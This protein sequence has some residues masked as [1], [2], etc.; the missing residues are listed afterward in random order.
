MLRYFENATVCRILIES[1]FTKEDIPLFETLF[2]K[3]NYS[4]WLVECGDIYTLDVAVVH[5]LYREIYTKHKPIEIRVHRGRLKRYLSRLGFSLQSAHRQ[6]MHVIDAHNIELVLIGGSADS[7]A[8][9]VE[10]VKRCSFENLSLIIVQ[11]QKPDVEANFDKVLQQYTHYKVVYAKEFQAIQKKHIYIAPPNKHLLVDEGRFVFSDA[12]KY[13]FSRPSISLSYESFSDYY[14][15]KLLV[16]Q[17]CGYLNDGVD[18][19]KKLKKNGSKI[20]VQCGEECLNDSDSMVKKALS[21]QVHNYC[22][23]VQD[24]VRYVNYLDKYDSK[25]Y[26]EFLTEEIKVAYGYD[27]R[28]YNYETIQRRLQAFIIKNRI[29]NLKDAVGAILFDKKIFK[30]FFLELSINVTQFFRNPP[31]YENLYDIFSTTFKHRKNL[32]IWSAGCSYGK[33]AVSLSILLASLDKLER[34]V[35][36]ATDINKTVLAEAKNGLYSLK[37]Y[38]EARE[39]LN[40]TTLDISLD[41]YFSKNEHFVTVQDFIKEKILYFEHNLATD[42][43]FNEFDVILCNN[44]IIYFQ[45]SLQKRVLTL[46][47]ESLK[48]GGYLVLGEREY[49]HKDF[50]SKFEKFSL[51]IPIFKKVN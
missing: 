44:V 1:S 39:N 46:L 4:R 33:E 18:K 26:L 20:I 3:Q 16:V 51:D 34:S 43:S 37:S 47:Y 30:K 12:Q 24:I 6:N 35:I 11:H 42:S 22:F 8:K 15:E 9:I 21:E 41:R 45:E 27:F 10:I 23:K 40:Q 28:Y 14:K 36:Y 38:E 32:K 29:K 31:V 19:L 49:I 7:S 2:E 25:R 50:A 17:E 5:I 13:N 48:F